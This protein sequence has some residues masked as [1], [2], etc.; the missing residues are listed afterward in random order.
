MDI[1][2]KLTEKFCRQDPSGMTIMTPFVVS[3]KNKTLYLH[4]AKTGGSSITDMLRAY[5]LDDKILTNKNLNFEKKKRVFIEIV[6][7]WN[8]YYKFTFVR[9]KYDLLVSHWYY[10]NA[11]LNVSFKDF[12][13]KI[14]VPNKDI[15]DYWIDQYYLTTIDGVP[16]FDF[17]GHNENFIDDLKIPFSKIGVKKYNPKK[18]VNSG[19]YDRSVH[20][21]SYY[22]EETKK[23]V[24]EKF[25]KEIEHFDFK[26]GEAKK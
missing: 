10:D 13:R 9:N 12:I 11:K 3:R 15:Y 14:V 1:K 2:D 22:D 20:Y 7:N 21:S 18:R 19:K 8:Q 24:D 25:K 26:M 5:R 16:I 17:V 23:L 4:I 6:E